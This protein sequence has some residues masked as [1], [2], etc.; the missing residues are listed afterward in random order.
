MLCASEQ[1]FY[2]IFKQAAVGIAQFDL[3]GKFVLANMTDTRKL[4]ADRQ[5]N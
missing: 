3:T 5:M 4:S 2:G 1:R